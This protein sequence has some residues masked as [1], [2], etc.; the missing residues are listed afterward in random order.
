MIR[1]RVLVL[2]F[3][4]VLC[5][6][7]RPLTVSGS[8]P[9]TVADA[10]KAWGN[11]NQKQVETILLDAVTKNPADIRANLGLAYL[12]SLQGKNEESWNAFR[13]VLEGEQNYYPY[14]YAVMSTERMR[15]ALKKSDSGAVVLLEKLSQSADSTGVLKAMACEMLGQYY[16]QRGDLA[17][18]NHY[19]SQMN[20]ITD[21]LVIGPFDNVSAS[22]HEKA[23][24][25]ENEFNVSK[26]YRG[27]ADISAKWFKLAAVKNDRWIEFTRYFAQVRSVFY[28]NNFVFS[29][30]KQTVQI[31]IG[32]SGSTKVFLNDELIIE[33]DEETNND[34]DTFIVSTELQEGWNRVLIKCGYSEIRLCNFLA[35]ITDERG[36]PVRGLQFGTD[37]K[38]YKSR[39][40]APNRPVEN[41]AESFFKA[42]VKDSPDHFENY[43]LLADCYLRNDKA[44]DAESV[45]REALRYYPNCAVFHH[46]MVEAYFS[47]RKHD[48]AATTIE[49]ICAIDSNVPKAIEYK[50]NEYLQNEEYDKAEELMNRVEKAMPGSEQAYEMQLGFYANKEQVDKLIELARESYARYPGNF[51]FAYIQS[52]IEFQTSRKYDRAIAV[53][54]DYLR[55]EYSE[56]ALSTLANYYLQA[57]DIKKWQETMGKIIEIDPA[58]TTTHFQMAAVYYSLQQYENAEKRL[59][60]AIELCPNNSTFWSK[61]GEIHRIKKQDGLSAKA[62]REALTYDPRDYDARR[63]L[64][65]LEG[66]KPVFAPFETADIAALIRNSPDAKAYPE[67]SGIVLLRDEKRVVYDR[68]ASESS[69]EL[70]V[71]VFN[72]SGIDEFKEYW[73]PFGP[74]TESLNVEKAV[75]IK[76]DG[77]EVKADVDTSHIVFKALEE[78][79]HIYLKW[80]I[81]NLYS[82]S[83]SQ[84][85]WDTFHF[86]HYYPAKTIRYSLLAPEDFKFQ[87]KAQNMPEQP[88]QRRTEDGVL[89]QWA[90][91]DEPAI[92]YEAAM[93]SLEDVGKVLY[94]SSVADWQTVVNWYSDLARSKTKR[95]YEVKEQVQELLKGEENLSSERKIE[96][97]YTFITENIRYSSVPFRQSALAPQ[98]ARDVLVNKIGDCKDLATLCIA[99]LAEAGIKAYYVLVN[100]RDAGANKN[101]LPAIPFN[102]CIVAVETDAGLKYLDLTAYNYPFG[103]IPTSDLGASSLLIKPGVKAPAY[104]PCDGFAPRRIT[105]RTKADILEDSS[106]SVRQDVVAEGATAASLREGYRNKG[107]SEREKTATEWLGTVF[108]NLKLTRLELDGI[109]E[110]TPQVK[111]RCNFVVPTYVG[112]AGQF[113]L[114]KLPWVESLEA[115]SALS[116]ESR[117]FPFFYWPWADTIVE[118]VVVKLPN[119]YELV[120]M[121][122]NVTL[123]SSVADYSLTFTFSQGIIT[124]RRQVTNKKALVAP[125]EY[126]EFKK[127][128]A[129]V[130]K[131]DDRQLL[132]RKTATNR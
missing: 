126:Q 2:G 98:K 29:P 129:S 40:G 118:E 42:R 15:T 109:D 103:A 16:Q 5:F 9:S 51:A 76:K 37:A 64:R 105:W 18:S 99:M 57:S 114:L 101:A 35:R 48:E 23:F 120:E 54:E 81:K 80:S 106:L 45:L 44:A 8:S 62:Y 4:L 125:D 117:K 89:Y 132:I 95:P 63:A 56:A 122:S 108:P 100:T 21:W 113:K 93:P 47:G 11:N 73:I 24:P 69:A 38:P 46:Q 49:K 119:G 34:L 79:D 90:L 74:Y 107:Q 55:R 112:E 32:T 72:K 67:D 26:T 115:S 1:R 3:L 97:I 19:Y 27:K 14:V 82:G 84:H 130:I 123:T 91:T 59:K 22:G 66:K 33:S 128:F 50:F 58:S 70:L 7:Q 68:G 43:L 110:L 88:L 30:A 116:Y 121:P 111:L 53:I 20:A 75:V 6:T 10:W 85:V 87:W 77:S 94:I 96:V 92:R 131:E 78:S 28:A 39:P 61:V 102:H 31:R 13:R 104:I 127:F 12:Y 60:E 41:F 124:A 52:A 65:E 36:E 71:K 25:P 17:N 86:S 83:I